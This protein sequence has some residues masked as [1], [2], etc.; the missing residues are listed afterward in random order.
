MDRLNLN[1]S[2]LGN[3]QLIYAKQLVGAPPSTVRGVPRI[4][5]QEIPVLIEERIL[6]VS[7]VYL[8]AKPTWNTAGWL[9]QEVD[10]P[11]DDGFTFEGVGGPNTTLDVA[12]ER[13][14]LNGNQLVIFDRVATQHRYRFEAAPWMP[15]LSLAIWAYIGPETDPTDELVQSLKVDVLRLETKV[16]AL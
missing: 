5:I 4:E 10:V 8:L 15:K 3:W 16:D 7:A 6:A 12:K 2:Q 11:L 13:I 14:D 9:Y 1:L